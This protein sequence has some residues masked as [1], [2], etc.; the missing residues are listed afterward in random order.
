M[1]ITVWGINYGPE[2][3]GIAPYNQALC[4]FLAREGHTVQMVT[5]FPYYP[6]WSK[7]GSDRGVG[8]RT[9]TIQGVT[10][11]R[12]WQ[13]VPSRPRTLTR[14]LHELSF[15]VTSFLRLLFLPRPD[16]FVVVSPPLL[17]GAAAW[18]L[19]R[20]R[21][22][23]FVFHVQDLQPDAA[24]ALGMLKRGWLARVLYA[25]EGFAYAKAQRVSG[26]S[27]GMMDAF[28]RKGVSPDATLYS[29]NGVALPEPSALPAKGQ[30]R[31]RHGWS[32]D[33]FLVVYSGNLGVKQGL[34]VLIEAAARIEDSRVRIV[35]CGDGARR[36]ALARL[37]AE[38]RLSNVT[39]L[40]LQPEAQFLELL[41]DTDLAVITQ[42]SGT[43]QFFFPS[44]LLRTLAMARPVL[45]VADPTSEL[46]RA[47][48]KGRFGVHSP[49]QR[50]EEVARVLQEL[51]GDP[52]RLRSMGEA[53]RA[54]VE[55][56]EF[57]KVLRDFVSALHRL[58]A[59]LKTSG[60]PAQAAAARFV[61]GEE[62]PTGKA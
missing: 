50:P 39:M 30:F 43:G 62:Q 37:V 19:T 42:E 16:V 49:P 32:A 35:I 11:D 3:T 59:L 2:L 57:S 40:P 55:Q 22:A 46:V 26:I 51:T 52:L 36:D 53:G 21:R 5:G 38:R 48:D 13:F 17:L 45:A 14:I 56:F 10:V 18:L 25:L 20:L 41:A 24:Y 33:T 34:E 47:L 54:F 9:E 6:N 28:L 8:F 27:Q 4:E 44:K 15:V 7:A 12:C 29:P 61:V 58:P 60:T 23:P 31:S 1:K